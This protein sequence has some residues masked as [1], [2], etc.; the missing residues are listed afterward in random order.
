MALRSSAPKPLRLFRWL[1]DRP[2]VF[3]LVTAAVMI[4]LG[5][6]T[7][8]DARAALVGGVV[9]GFFIYVAWRPGGFGWRLDAHQTHLLEERGDLGVRAAWLIRAAAIAASALVLVLLVLL[10]VS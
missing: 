6:L 9:S 2:E 7:F 8:G 3:A 1:R 10:V 4:P 5:L